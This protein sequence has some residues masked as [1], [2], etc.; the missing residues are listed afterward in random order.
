MVVP[1]SAADAEPAPDWLKAI[2]IRLRLAPENGALL[3]VRDGTAAALRRLVEVLLDVD[4]ECEVLASAAGLDRIGS[5]RVVLLRVVPD[6]LRALNLVRPLLAERRLRV[7][8]W[9]E[10][11]N[12]DTVATRASDLWSWVQAVFTPPAALPVFVA[13]GLELALEWGWVAWTGERVPVARSHRLSAEDEYASIVSALHDV[14]EGGVVTWGRPDGWALQRIEWA[15]AE[16][17]GRVALIDGPAP[18]G[19]WPVDGTCSDFGVASAMLAE[20]GLARPALVAAQHELEPEVIDVLA[21]KAQA[22]LGPL[23][24]RTRGRAAWEAA[25]D[26]GNEAI[27]WRLGRDLPD[28]PDAWATDRTSA[29]RM[30]ACLG[31]SL[32]RSARDGLA[33]PNVFDHVNF[34]EYLDQW[35]RARKAASPRFGYRAFAAKVGSRDPSLLTNI[36]RGRRP[37][38]D[39]RLD[40]FVRVIGLEGDSAEYFRLLVRF[41]QAGDAAARERARA[42][43]TELRG[44]STGSA[45]DPVGLAERALA[46]GHPDTARAWSEGRLGPAAELVRAET[47]F[48]TGHVRRA[49]RGF[50]HV[51]ADPDVPERHRRAA[52]L[53]WA[54][55]GQ[56]LAPEVATL[57]G[58][59]TAEG[60]TAE[61]ALHRADACAGLAAIASIRG[62]VVAADRWSDRA[63]AEIAGL[64]DVHAAV[65]V[66][67]VVADIATRRGAFDVARESMQRV[68]AGFDQRI[69]HRIHPTALDAAR[70][71]ALAHVEEAPEE[72]YRI[73]M[74]H[75]PRRRT[76]RGNVA[77]LAWLASVGVVELQLGR[78]DSAWARLQQALDLEPSVLGAG[79]VRPMLLV[80][81]AQAMVASGRAS[82]ALPVAR[83][84]V[85]S[86]SDRD[87]PD[88]H[89]TALLLEARASRL[90]G[91]PAPDVARRAVEAAVGPVARADA[92]VEL[93]AVHRGAKD[94]VAADRALERA[95]DELRTVGPE[96]G[97]RLPGILLQLATRAQERGDPEAA[98]R[99]LREASSY[100]AGPGLLVSTLVQV[101]LAWLSA[102]AAPKDPE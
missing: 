85:A 36:I 31:R 88:L 11:G 81:S 27:A 57:E 2:G 4:P 20:A 97:S 94:A 84:A 39:D 13:R 78:A 82:E 80:A 51:A 53:A 68:L 38:A 65:S 96:A 83:E 42:A 98:E 63:V 91:V 64:V 90:A 47:D 28:P 54:R 93:A 22:A 79:P 23:A 59:A 99:M 60:S 44:R 48:R 45:L 74:D 49:L 9:T 73:L 46:H 37:L 18:P 100:G 43:L 72:A 95:A 40:A 58:E 86:T 50:A 41:G 66:H 102:A 101:A 26:G 14:P 56:V 6:E 1:P 76:V 62:D 19:W 29:Q 75:R 12:A 15:H 17:P 33:L 35:L 34:R 32:T 87:P 25:A 77:E 30:A 24:L 10:P 16:V 52:R 8:L 7:V 21:G 89:G 3:L 70:T 55:H 92:L 67:I 61:M 71:L 5:D 69:G